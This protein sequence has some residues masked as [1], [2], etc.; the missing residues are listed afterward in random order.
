LS[1]INL[2]YY[3]DVGYVLFQQ[4]IHYVMSF[5]NTFHDIYIQN[6]QKDIVIKCL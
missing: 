4:S 2:I 5:I 3:I 6:D 1:T